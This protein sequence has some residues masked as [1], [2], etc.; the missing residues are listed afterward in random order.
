VLI[1]LGASA[2]VSMELT[3]FQC[4]EYFSLYTQP[5]GLYSPKKP[6]SAFAMH[7]RNAS[8]SF[9]QPVELVVSANTNLADWKL[10]AAQAKIVIIVTTSV[11]AEKPTSD[12]SVLSWSAER[13]SR[14][15]ESV[16]YRKPPRP[17]YIHCDGGPSDSHK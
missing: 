7:R 4:G 13:D 11:V 8:P 1:V 3:L 5:Q 12:E 16:P 2:A 10:G 9:D 14:T 15:D 17:K 6:Y